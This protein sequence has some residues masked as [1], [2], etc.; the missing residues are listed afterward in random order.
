MIVMVAV[1]A[2]LS[3]LVLFEAFFDLGISE[4]FK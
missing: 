2:I 3:A 1:I 4:Y